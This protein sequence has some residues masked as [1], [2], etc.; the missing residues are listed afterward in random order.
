[1]PDQE[2][3]LYELQRF[4][5]DCTYGREPQW[6]A[7]AAEYLEDDLIIPPKMMGRS[8]VAGLMF[9]H[10]PTVH[11]WPKSPSVSVII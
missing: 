6:I 2:N 5:S 7:T 1:V 11:R 8:L 10:P 4:G 9:G 3:G